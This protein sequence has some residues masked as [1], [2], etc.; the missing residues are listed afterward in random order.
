[1]DSWTDQK[2]LF[3]DAC[4]LLEETLLVSLGVN[5]NS[6]NDYKVPGCEHLLLK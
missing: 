6:E 1:M 2:E 5:E 4:I 3:T